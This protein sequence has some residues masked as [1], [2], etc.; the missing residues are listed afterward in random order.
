MTAVEWFR[1]QSVKYLCNPSLKRTSFSTFT[2]E[3]YQTKLVYSYFFYFL[4]TFT[5][6]QSLAYTI[7]VSVITVEMLHG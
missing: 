7:N 4:T 1:F 5:I 6:Q 2:A 3:I